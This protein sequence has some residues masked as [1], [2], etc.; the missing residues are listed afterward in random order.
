[1]NTFS[2]S[3][4]FIFGLL[5][6]F[7]FSDLLRELGLKKEHANSII[8]IFILPFISLIVFLIYPIF[9]S[10]ALVFQDISLFYSTSDGLFL[11]LT[12]AL[13]IGAGARFALHYMKPGFLE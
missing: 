6:G 7:V 10:G 13:F 11:W 2:S 12:V 3:L 5:F 1:M 8:A 9:V 4:I